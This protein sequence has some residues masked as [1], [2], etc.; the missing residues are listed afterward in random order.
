MHLAERDGHR[1]RER[2]R[3]EANGSTS[4]AFV[5]D[6]TDKVWAKDPVVALYRSILQALRAGAKPE[7][8]YNFYGMGVA[9]TMVDAL[10][11]AGKNPTRASL[12]AAATHLNEVNPF[13]RPGI[14]IVTTPDRL[15]P[16]LEGAARALRPHPL[17][18]GGAARFCARLNRRSS[19]GL[20]PPA[21]ATAGERSE[22]DRDPPVNRLTPPS[23][24]IRKGHQ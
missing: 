20:R 8:V 4:I 24:P 15:L 23:V 22:F 10:K 21:F 5:K 1:P 7:D 19:T 11:H 3:L 12:L 18:R 6:P 16:D 13:M 9:Y 2:A 14:K 17:G